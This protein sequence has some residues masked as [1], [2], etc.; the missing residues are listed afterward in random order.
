MHYCRYLAEF[1]TGAE[2]KESAE[3]TMVAYKAAQVCSFCCFAVSTTIV[4]LF[5]C[6]KRCIFHLNAYC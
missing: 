6:H 1:K 2:R 5:S 4:T 3:S